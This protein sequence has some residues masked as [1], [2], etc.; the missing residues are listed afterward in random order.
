MKQNSFSKKRIIHIY[1]VILII[2]LIFLMA[3]FFMLKYSVE[4]EK[5]LPFK[6]EKINV[7]ST[8]ESDIK[9][10]DD[11]NWHAGILQ[12]NDIFLS[13][14]KNDKYKKLDTIKSIKLENFQ[15]EKSNE[16]MQIK[17]YRPK[18][19]NFDYFYSEDFVVA[20]TIQFDGGLETNLEAL[21]INNQ[22]ATLGFSIAVE[23]LGEYAF[24][25]NEKVPS[26][27][28]ILA[29]A[30]L[31]TE[32]IKFTVLFDLIIETGSNNK[33]KSTITLELPTGDILTEGVSSYED[34]ELK[35]IIFK[36]IR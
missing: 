29:K 35:D 21:Q 25:L 15:I 5:N 34:T 28:K 22:G 16:N 14:D 12:E 19:N 10:D 13:L 1:I 36:R 23:N 33:F 20:D 3:V 7:I 31:K 11:E 6:I 30:G 26:D 18:S 4:G 32:D 8:A 27:G 9:Q 17:I 2:V 24:S